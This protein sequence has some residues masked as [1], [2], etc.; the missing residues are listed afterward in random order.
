MP[1]FAVTLHTDR[2]AGCCGERDDAKA[3][4]AAR[5]ECGFIRSKRPWARIFQAE[6]RRRHSKN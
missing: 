5:S 3:G 4:M 6:R 1:A 2:G